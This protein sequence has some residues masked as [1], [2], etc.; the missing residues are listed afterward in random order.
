MNPKEQTPHQERE[1]GRASAPLLFILAFTAAGLTLIAGTGQGRKETDRKDDPACKYGERK[2]GEQDGKPICMREIMHQIV[3][4]ACTKSDNANGVDC[5]CIKKCTWNGSW[6]YATFGDLVSTN[7]MTN[8]VANGGKF[9]ASWSNI[10]S[11]VYNK[12]NG[13]KTVVHEVVT[14]V[15]DQCLWKD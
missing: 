9:D 11:I 7:R 3:C 12:Q 8:T 14:T 5:K 6:D 10:V 4:N 2:N 13:T 1:R 15:K